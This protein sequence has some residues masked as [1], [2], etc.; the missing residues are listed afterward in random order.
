MVR[1]KRLQLAIITVIG[2]VAARTYY[3]WLIA[4]GA[5]KSALH[6]FG[7]P[8]YWSLLAIPALVL[9]FLFCVIAFR[10][11]TI[12]AGWILGGAV[13]A[14]SVVAYLG[15]F[16]DVLFCVFVTRGACE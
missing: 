4:S 9:F 2:F 12:G 11:P 15:L 7:V 3:Q 10:R 13:L 6:S 8:G 5:L 14:A 16:G 1:S